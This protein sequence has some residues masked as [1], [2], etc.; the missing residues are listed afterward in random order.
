MAMLRAPSAFA[1]ATRR[2]PSR[3]ACTT[4][5]LHRIIVPQRANRVLAGPAQEP[6]ER[7]TPHTLRRTFATF[8]RS[9]RSW[10]RSLGDACCHEKRWTARARLV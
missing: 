1:T 5:I 6:I 7:L 9:R 2:S 8:A 3:I 10:R 4:R